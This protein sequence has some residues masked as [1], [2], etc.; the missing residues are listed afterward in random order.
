MLSCIFLNREFKSPSPH[1]L[2]NSFLKKFKILLIKDTFSSDFNIGSATRFFPV[3]FSSIST[4]IVSPSFPE[5][6]SGIFS[7]KQSLFLHTS[8]VQGFSSS[9]STLS[10]HTTLEI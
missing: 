5:A 3:L 4:F 9:Q 1:Y 6:Q 7:L 8:V 2:P 10:L